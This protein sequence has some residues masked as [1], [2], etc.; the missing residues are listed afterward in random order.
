MSFEICRWP[1]I[2]FLITIQ[3]N[4]NHSGVTGSY[5]GTVTPVAK[6]QT[7]P[8]VCLVFSNIFFIKTFE[9]LVIYFSLYFIILH[10]I[11]DIHL[12][13]LKPLRTKQNIYIYIE[14]LKKKYFFSTENLRKLRM[15]IFSDSVLEN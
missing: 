12:Y 2:W 13:Q 10:N 4:W 1:Y 15:L 5:L 14:N 6:Y 8:S 9:I 7:V 3:Q 11:I